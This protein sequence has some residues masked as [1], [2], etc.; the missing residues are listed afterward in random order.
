MQDR[1]FGFILPSMGQERRLAARFSIRQ[2]I[3]LGEGREEYLWAK[4]LNLSKT[5]LGCIS[6]KA[7]QPLDR[8]F[9]MI[10]VE[11]GDAVRD[12]NFEGYIVRAKPLEQG[13]ELGISFTD[14]DPEDE[15]F[16]DS[17][18]ALPV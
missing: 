17:T 13:C 14:L 8:I 6:S 9:G 11:V 10:S 3:Q 5:G 15:Q 18:Q 1:R 7:L 4:S 16:L 2:M 12:I